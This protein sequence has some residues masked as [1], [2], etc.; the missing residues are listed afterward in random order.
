MSWKRDQCEWD[1]GET[2]HSAGVRG[3]QWPAAPGNSA[4]S[5][6]RRLSEDKQKLATWDQL[7]SEEQALGDTYGSWNAVVKM[8]EKL[9]LHGVLV[10]VFWILLIVATVLG[11]NRPDREAVST[12]CRSSGG[13][14]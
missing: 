9:Y 6:L 3:D 7:I 11:A 8:R 4:V 13:S 1:S 10:S 5:I 14:F 2:S 12:R